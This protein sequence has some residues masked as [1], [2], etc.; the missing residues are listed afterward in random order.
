MSD[1]IYDHPRYYEIAFSFRDVAAEVDVME[2]AIHWFSDIP[3]E[4]VLEVA[5]GNS[6][7]AAE[8]VRRGKRYVGIDLSETMLDFAGR[9]LAPLGDK[10]QLIRA[11][12]ADFTL[13]EPVDFAYVMLASLY[14]DTTEK[15]RD[16][17]DC[18][19]KAIRPGGL[20]LLDWVV[21][22]E[23]FSGFANAWES[24][25]DGVRVQTT[26]LANLVDRVEQTVE[27]KITLEV[28][29]GGTRTVLSQ[30]TRKRAIYPQEFRIL[31]EWRGHFEFLG[32]WNDWDLTV[33]V[34]G[35]DTITRPLTIIR[36]KKSNG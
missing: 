21:E 24:E 10:A 29:D 33:P 28:D 35:R 1:R 4:R 3:V 32:W 6:P 2:E 31:L 26:Y 17:F 7:H 16:H 13:D 23:P 11:D 22:F 15:L 8:W 14:V 36:R 18:M 27:E 12:M 25:R 19:A 30:E 20:Y 9:K 5:S 34:N